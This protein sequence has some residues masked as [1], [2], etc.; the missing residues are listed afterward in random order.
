MNYQ[1]TLQEQEI[2]SIIEGLLE[3]K[4]KVCNPIINKIKIQLTQQENDRSSKS[5]ESAV[6]SPE[7]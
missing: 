1:I 4:G 2:R 5:E 3:L 7:A 6:S